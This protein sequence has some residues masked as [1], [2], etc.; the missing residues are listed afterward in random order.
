MRM[1]SRQP[2]AIMKS[3][4]AMV[5]ILLVFAEPCASEFEAAPGQGIT[6]IIRL[7]S[8]NYI[9]F[10]VYGYVSGWSLDPANSP[11]SSSG[12]L[13]LSTDSAWSV[14]VTSDTGGYLIEYDND[15]G[16]YIENGKALKSPMEIYVRSTESYTGYK[17]VPSNGALLVEGSGIYSG[18]IPFTYEQSTDWQDEP[19][20]ENHV[21]RMV[22]T[23]TASSYG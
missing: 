19:L 11:A 9:L 4:A 1:S 16:E 14:T 22:I 10:S 2:L 17:A 7:E 5:L 3:I 8:E 13:S 21:Y 12:S 15:L 6:D 20:Q 18:T 23:F